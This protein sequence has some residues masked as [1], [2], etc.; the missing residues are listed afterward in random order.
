VPTL[1]TKGDLSLVD[2]SYYLIKDGYGV[3][4]DASPHVYFQTNKTMIKAFNNVDGS[5][6]LTA[7]IVLRDGSTQVSPFVVLDV[8]STSS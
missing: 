3:A 4:I 7:P 6:W 8:P 2:F 5:P 1:G